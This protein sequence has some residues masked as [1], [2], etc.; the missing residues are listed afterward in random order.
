MST[1]GRLA[2][3]TQFRKKLYHIAEDIVLVLPS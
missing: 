2:Q 1:I 3:A